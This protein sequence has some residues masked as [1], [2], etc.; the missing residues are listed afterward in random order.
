M[1]K[2]IVSAA[3]VA[4]IVSFAVGFIGPIAAKAATTPALATDA[5][6]AILSSTFTNSNTSPQT[7]ITG[8]VCYTTGPTTVP[9]TINGATSTPCAP[10]T[11]TD[12]GLALANLNGQACTSLGAGAVALDSIVV[13]I[14]PPGTFPPGCY[15]SGGAM[16]I[17]LGTTVTLNGAGTY[18]FRPGGALTTGANS[19]VALAGGASAADVFWAPTALT[20]LGANAALSVTPT[21]VGTI[22]DAAGITLGH[23]ANLLGRALAFG[24]TV[25]TD[26]NTI[27]VPSGSSLATLRVIKLLVNGN[28]IAAPSDFTVHVKSAGVDVGGSPLPGAAAPGTSYSLSA[29]TYTVSENANAGYVQTFTG[30]CDANGVVALVSLDDKTCTIVNTVAPLANVGVAGGSSIIVPLIGL[31]KVP[32]PLALPGGSGPVTYGYTVWN[33]GGQQALAN[34]TLTDDKC[35]PVALLSGD[36]NS[37]GKLDPGEN[38]KYSCTVTLSKTTTNTAIATGHSDDSFNQPTIATAIA[39]VVVGAPIAPPLINI[40][41]VPSRLTPFPF[42]GGPVTYAYAVTNPGVVA[43]HDVTVS[44]NKCAPVAGPFSG[45]TNSNNLLDPGET[46]TYTCQA[47]IAVSTRNVATAQGKANGLTAF[48]YA[49][50]DVLVAAPG[51]PNTGTPPDE[52]HTPWTAAL[53]IGILAIVSSSLIVAARKRIV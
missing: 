35:G 11:N 41:K 15:S 46:W 20:T 10:Q 1:K 32:N 23:F 26:A 29:G 33:V 17:T 27:T 53:I 38:W 39:T 14:N 44:D 3:V 24:G 45:D 31:L 7:I 22:I 36:T 2:Y 5:P 42:G 18:V 37:N 21:F 6:F 8:N 51:L 52:P 43:M 13:G 40:V 19:V 16:N 50:S 25:T 49:F 9:L 48:G 34:V 4:L 30:A 12:Q 47:N 28:G